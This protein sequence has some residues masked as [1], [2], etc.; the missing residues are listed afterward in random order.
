MVFQRG[1][2][3]LSS[4]PDLVEKLADLQAEFK[5]R[6]GLSDV[7]LR[8]KLPQESDSKLEAITIPLSPETQR[9]V[10]QM[11][12]DG[13]AV[14]DT[15]GR[16]PASLKSDGMRYWVLNDKLAERTAP[17]KLVAFKKAPSEFFLPGS[18]DML[19]DEQV[20][21]IPNAQAQLDSEYPGK[22]LLARE[23]K[24]SEWTEVALKHFKETSKTGRGVR[25]LGSD[26]GY[27]WTWADDYESDERGADRA[28]FGDWYDASGAFV[29]LWS[30]DLVV[31][32]LRLALLVEIPLK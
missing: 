24:I 28:I 22:G 26:Y 17:Q 13:Y 8:G 1:K 12:T 7:P 14:Y 10:E 5:V 9:L 25:I 30:P 20:M 18:E 16:T 27:K 15:T 32:D 3:A 29:E 4:Y 19:H 31:S 11:R 6:S 21:L 23:G 2:E